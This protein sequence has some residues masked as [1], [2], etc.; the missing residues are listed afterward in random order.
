VIALVL[1]AGGFLFFKLR[2]PDGGLFKAPGSSGTRQFKD[3]ETKTGRV[4]GNVYRQEDGELSDRPQYSDNLYGDAVTGSGL[5][6]KTTLKNGTADVY[7][8]VSPGTV[9]TDYAELSEY[10]EMPTTSTHV[11][12]YIDLGYGINV[13]LEG[14][15]R[16]LSDPA[17]VVFDFSKGKKLEEFKG[18]TA[19]NNHCD[20]SNPTFLPEVCASLLNIPA[21]E[22]LNSKYIAVSPKYADDKTPTF[23]VYS[24]YLGTDDLLVVRVDESVI[25]IP[26]PLT[27][28][29]AMDLVASSFQ[30]YA[31]FHELYEALD[32]ARNLELEITDEAVLFDMR[33]KVNSEEFK[34]LYA[35][36]YLEGLIEKAEDKQNLER[37]RETNATLRDEVLEQF[38]KD[39]K[40]DLGNKTV[41]GG[42]NLR[43]AYDAKLKG[44]AKWAHATLNE[45]LDDF[46]SYDEDEKLSVIESMLILIG[47]MKY[48][49]LASAGIFDSGLLAKVLGSHTSL[50]QD[51]S[52]DRAA[53]E[54][55]GSAARAALVAE[56]RATI[57][58]TLSYES[59]SYE[60]LIRALAMAQTF[61]ELSEFE[62]QIK[63]KIEDK[64]REEVEDALDGVDD[65]VLAALPKCQAVLSDEEC[66]ELENEA[67]IILRNRC[68]VQVGKKTLKNFADQSVDKVICD[69]LF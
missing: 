38:S 34:S 57:V 42:A 21:G 32:I 62:D 2:S 44:S 18:L 41:I 50:P 59:P 15:G 10:S 29:L 8:I 1:L 14:S 54:N 12:L 56:A 46:D 36:N 49:P 31:L 33:Q 28:E 7:L 11:P 58:E 23:P 5:S 30:K 48:K 66:E 67:K 25:I 52:T 26:Q 60:S 68:Y 69:D 4:T 65:D 24:Y 63:K 17:Y 55:E 19:E 3:I 16:G 22:T 43:R 53:F 40:G 47:D 35:G 20:Y 61:D 13:A 6:I 51:S 9:G 37:I 27:R 64:V 45:V 39:A